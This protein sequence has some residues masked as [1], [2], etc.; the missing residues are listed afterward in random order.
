MLVPATPGLHHRNHPDL[1]E[2]LK[3]E[4][5]LWSALAQ[6]PSY[7]AKKFCVAPAALALAPLNALIAP[8]Q[9]AHKLRQRQQKGRAALGGG[10]VRGHPA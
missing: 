10:R 8:V 4:R 2:V 3:T 7:K 5:V 6:M 1:S 9:T